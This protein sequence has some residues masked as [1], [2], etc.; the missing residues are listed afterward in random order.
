M[1]QFLLATV[2]IF[3]MITGEAQMA[4]EKGL[5]T[6]THESIEGQLEFL[7]SDWMEGR[8]TGSRGIYMAADYLA[9]MF[10]VYNIQPFGDEVTV[11]PTREEIR[12]GKRPVTK[13]SYFQNVALLRYEPGDIQ[14]LSIITKKGPGETSVILGHKVDFQIQTGNTSISGNAPLFFAGYGI[15]DKDYDEFARKDI[16][17]KVVVLLAG[18]PGHRDS[19]SAAYKKFK[20][21]MQPSGRI[22]PE[23]NKINKAEEL[24]AAAVIVVNPYSNP[25]LGWNSN[26]PYPVKGTYYEADQKLPSFYDKRL[27]L[28]GD[29]LR[30]NIPVF[31][32]TQ[33]IANHII[34]GTG[35]NFTAFEKHAMDNMQPASVDLPGKEASWN[36]TVK[37][38]VIKCRNVVG[39]IEGKNKEEFIVVGGHYDHVGKYAGWIWNG[40]D[41]NGSGTV[42]VMSLARA[43]AESGEKPEKSIIFAAWTGE[44]MGLWGSKYFVNNFPKNLSIAYNLNLDMISRDEEN[45]TKKNKM[46][47]MYLSSTPGLKELTEKNIRDFKINLDVDFKPSAILSGGSDHAPFAAAGIPVTFFFAAM[48]PDYHQPSDELSKIN[49][50][51]MLNIIHLGY[52]N[53]WELANSNN[54]L[55]KK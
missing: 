39:Y 31:T 55:E 17:G 37:A 41:D 53:V 12:E 46:S 34:D 32:I 54:Y 40:A 45:D 28:P 24:G 25:A 27:M 13:K 22:S 7:A 14:E 26:D 42:G 48:H 11:M 43:F 2:L 35:I 3:S 20:P 52:L 10:K 44:E 36:S 8:A 19:T 33:R 47:M 38:D 4:R 15:S 21:K 18:Y 6:I 23:R 30:G 9:S 29:T 5:S 49:W 51:K 50:Q 16:K 1:R